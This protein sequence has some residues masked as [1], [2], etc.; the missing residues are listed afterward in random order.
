MLQLRDR[1]SGILILCIGFFV[2]GLLSTVIGVTIPNIKQEFDISNEQAGL[3]FVYWSVGTLL[4]SYIGGRVYHAARTKTLF[5]ATAVTSIVCLVL[6]YGEQDLLRYKLYIFLVSLSGSIFFTAGHATAAHVSISNRASTLSFMDF[7]VSLGNLSTPFLVN[8]FVSSDGWVRDDW[9]M[10]FVVATGLLVVV[11]GLT[12]TTN[13]DALDAVRSTAAGKID[14]LSALAHPMV[15][16]LMMASLFLHATEWGHSVWFVTYAHEVVGLSPEEARETFSLFLIG[17]ASSRLLAS[18]LTWLFRPM[19]LMAALI[20]IAT[21]A[22]VSISNYQDY[23]A[24]R[25]L[26]FMFGFGIGALFPLLLGLSMDRAPAQAQLLSSVGLMAGTLGAKGASYTIGLFADQSSLGESYRY[27]SWATIALLGSVLTFLSF[28][29]SFPKIKAAAAAALVPASGDA[30][31]GVAQG[32][33]AAP[34]GE[35]GAAPV[36]FEFD[37]RPP[38]R[39]LGHVAWG[40]LGRLRGAIGYLVGNEPPRPEAP[41]RGDPRY[42][43]LEV[44]LKRDFEEQFRDRRRLT[45]EEALQF[46]NDVWSRYPTMK[47]LYP[48]PA[49]MVNAGWQDPAP[50]T[51]QFP[52]TRTLNAHHSRPGVLRS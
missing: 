10:V 48:S 44:E 38:T 47:E 25:V 11:V 46:L 20:A 22:A 2:F 13:L 8:Y 43:L 9:R 3:I 31:L 1:K 34:Q 51:T 32:Q 26:N 23:Y 36:Q 30:P 14:H 4:G 12:L 49:E 6:L 29:S 33:P 42:G 39:A 27:V 15:L 7:A 35:G 5:T 45:R 28:Y 41:H 24:L 19:T 52:E 17:M 37:F 50:K 16:V 40:P 18:W 21:V